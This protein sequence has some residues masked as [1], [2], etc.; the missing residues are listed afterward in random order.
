MK[1][2]DETQGAHV[3]E[4]GN[5]KRCVACSYHIIIGELRIAYK[6]LA[7][8]IVQYPWD[9]FIMATSCV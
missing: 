1:L 7:T 2:K 6:P 8:D 3:Q 5:E 9:K 4:L